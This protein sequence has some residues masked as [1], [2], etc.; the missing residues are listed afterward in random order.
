V[1]LFEKILVPLD[2]SEH[3]LR[4]LE[5][6]IQI[7][8]KFEGKIALIHIYSVAAR[9]LIMPEP[10]TLTPP[11][12]P[13][14]TGAEVARMVE[15]ARTAGGNI[16]ADGEKR[17]KTQEV[18]VEKILQ[19]GHVVD[20]IVKTVKE[21]KF[22]LIV[23]GDRGISKMRELLLGSVTDGVIHHVSCPVLVVKLV[24]RQ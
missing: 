12:I 9:P 19:E 21:G 8:K 14:M 5:I 7:A 20:E 23:I 16:L 2:G 3:S 11:G 15:A 4:A 6:A 18:P 10:T 22:D 17:V 13:V 1:P 24:P